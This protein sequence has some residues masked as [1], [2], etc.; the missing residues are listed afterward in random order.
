VTFELIKIIKAEPR[1]DY[2]VQVWFSNGEAGERDFADLVA[3]GGEVVEPLRDPAQFAR[4]FVQNGVLAWPS[5]F[6]LDA[7]AL[8]REMADAGLLKA[9]AAA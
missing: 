7:I 9:A 2:R 5:G 6:D 1:G 4:V 8:H 3:G